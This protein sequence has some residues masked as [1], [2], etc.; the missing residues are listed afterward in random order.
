MTRET[1][2]AML[3]GLLLIVLFGLVLSEL[4]G[5]STS[6]PPAGVVENR[7]YVLHPVPEPRGEVGA[8]PRP[9][10][11]ILEED[12]GSRVEGG[13][14]GQR[15][16]T[17][18]EPE[19]QVSLA[20]P[21][22]RSG[23]TPAAIETRKPP[24][25]VPPGTG[26][27]VAASAPPQPGPQMHKVR[28]SDTL[29]GIAVKFYGPGRGQEYKRIFLANRDRIKDPSAIRVGQ[30]LVIPAI[31]EPPGARRPRAGSPGVSDGGQRRPS[32]PLRRTPS[33][34]PPVRTAPGS[35]YRLVTL[36]ELPRALSEDAAARRTRRYVVRRG[37]SLT[38][39]A[40]HFL[41]DGSRRAVLRIYEANRDKLR[42]P[43]SLPVG[44]ELR[45]PDQS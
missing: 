38:K 19:V 39:I 41:K 13:L 2:I 12:I 42:S 28:P 18:R 10:P 21:A 33:P 45:I 29:I 25:S 4:T 30:E 3:V 22:G 16:R 23:H 24:G 36:D 8:P 32:V 43:D 5:A 1:R 14:V 37:D 40:R 15:P 9:V 35:D 34:G 26:P 17:E 11:V 31:A 6:S 27:R 7:P 44:I 20:P